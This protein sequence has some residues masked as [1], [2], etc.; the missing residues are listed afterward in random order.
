VSC[1]QSHPSVVA[2]GERLVRRSA[3]RQQRW[4][5]RLYDRRRGDSVAAVGFKTKLKDVWDLEAFAGMLHARAVRVIALRRRHLVKL[6]VSTVNARRLVERTGRWNRRVGGQPLPPLTIAAD[7]LAASIDACATRQDELDRYVGTLGL[8][9]LAL[10]Y[11]D[12]LVDPDAWL[13]V[14]ASFLGLGELPADSDVAKATDDDLRRA[15]RNYDELAIALAD[16]P[17]AR[18]FTE[19][20]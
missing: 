15:V 19:D 13:G 9:T 2:E 6:A 17:Y 16:G 11:D 10:D 20:A 1:L 7:E 3:W 5:R 4:I 14:V 18:F 12:L 8:E